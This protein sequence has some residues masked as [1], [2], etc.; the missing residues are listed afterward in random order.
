MGLAPIPVGRVGG[1]GGGAA[2]IQSQT[3]QVQTTP[4]RPSQI[5]KDSFNLNPP[6]PPVDYA[7]A[8]YDKLKAWANR[9]RAQ[10]AGDESADFEAGRAQMPRLSDE[11]FPMRLQRARDAMLSEEAAGGEETDML[12]R[13][14]NLRGGPMRG[15]GADLARIAEAQQA[16]FATPREPTLAEQFAETRL[17]RPELP[18][19][20]MGSVESSFQRVGRGFVGDKPPRIADPFGS[21]AGRSMGGGDQFQSAVSEFQPRVVETPREPLTSSRIASI[22][23]ELET[24]RIQSRVAKYRAKGKIEDTP[25]TARTEATEEPLGDMLERDFGVSRSFSEPVRGAPNFEVPAR[26][27]PV[28]YGR[29]PFASGEEIPVESTVPTATTAEASAVADAGAEVA[30]A[31]EAVEAGAM[32]AEAL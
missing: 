1:G 8:G 16:D 21:E 18:T 26:V 14:D 32:V 29:N 4:A 27:A 30:E 9:R 23:Q 31:G 25:R 13:L 2:R 20:E 6:I 22:N 10:T 7:K 17:P 19:R 24:R 11:S 28:N 12:Q 15:P 5:E 3:L